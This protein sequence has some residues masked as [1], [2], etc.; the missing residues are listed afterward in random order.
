P[1][2][3]ALEL[4]EESSWCESRRAAPEP[5]GAAGAAEPRAEGSEPGGEAPEPSEAEPG[6]ASLPPRA[7]WLQQ[8]Q[9]RARQVACAVRLPC[10]SGAKPI[11]CRL[12]D[13]R[14]RR[15]DRRRRR[16]VRAGRPVEEAA[17]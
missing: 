4:G 8:P 3:P 5:S 13:G 15:N 14:A 7:R 6:G 9:P 12:T 17:D 11:H 10:G 1:A 2:A 16:R